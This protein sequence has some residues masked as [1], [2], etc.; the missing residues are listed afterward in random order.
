MT[1]AGAHHELDR[2][3]GRMALTTTS[4]IHEAQ[5]HLHRT[6][7]PAAVVYRGGRPVGVVTAGALARAA[8]GRGSGVP[9]AQ[10]MDYVTVP[11]DAH[12]DAEQILH[13]FTRA[14]TDWLG[15]TH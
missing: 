13:R 3:A 6:G 10:V 4:C 5:A 1:E 14:A 12:V 9:L 11:V 2:A 7:E 15:H 8:Q